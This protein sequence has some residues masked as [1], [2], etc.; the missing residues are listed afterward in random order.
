MPVSVM[1]L[2]ECFSSSL[3]GF[4]LLAQVV[5]Q[6]PLLRRVSSDLRAGFYFMPQLF[7]RIKNK[8]ISFALRRLTVFVDLQVKREAPGPLRLAPNSSH[9]ALCA[10]RIALCTAKT[11]PGTSWSPSGT[12]RSPSPIAPPLP[13]KKVPVNP[14]RLNAARGIRLGAVHQIVEGINFQRL[15][16]RK[17][18]CH[19]VRFTARVIVFQP[20]PEISRPR[21]TNR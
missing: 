3:N 13:L 18:H 17:I 21:R 10:R 15:I 8:L 2:L 12:A 6:I 19:L 14:H 1:W 16:Q 4:Q 5:L 20:P 11:W 7:G 9:R